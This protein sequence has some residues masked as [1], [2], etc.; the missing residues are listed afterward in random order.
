MT[1]HKEE[2]LHHNPDIYWS[3]DGGTILHDL[4]KAK[5]KKDGLISEETEE[6]DHQ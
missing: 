3:N 5:A 4:R 1:D 6:V 2:D